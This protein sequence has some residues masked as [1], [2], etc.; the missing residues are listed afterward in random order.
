ML[1]ARCAEGFQ[2]LHKFWWGYTIALG[3]IILLWLVKELIDFFAV[4]SSNRH[5]ADF[6]K[7]GLLHPL[8]KVAAI[9]L[10]CLLCLALHHLGLNVSPAVMLPPRHCMFP[11]RFFLFPLRTA[12]FVKHSICIDVDAAPLF[13]TPV[14]CIDTAPSAVPCSRRGLSMAA[15]HQCS[16]SRTGPFRGRPLMMESVCCS[17]MATTVSWVSSQAA[18]LTSPTAHPQSRCSRCRE[19]RQYN[20]RTQIS[21]P[22][23]V[24]ET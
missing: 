6:L 18:M 1:A 15:S 20:E 8:C 19:A 12:F 4:L 9:I 17:R 11:L 5:S 14:R 16:C 3:A 10:R 2:E 22:A 23:L 7:V 21:K 13:V 24:Y